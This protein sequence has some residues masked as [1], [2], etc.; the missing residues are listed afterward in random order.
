MIPAKLIEKKR[1]GIE[2]TPEE[3]D[4]FISD[5]MNEKIDDSQLSALLMSIYFN[6][7]SD[8]ETKSLVNS[9]VK[10]GKRFNF[11]HLNRYV[12]D[13]HSTGGIGDKISFILA[14]LLSSFD[15]IVPM[16][17]GRGLA[18][19]GG[20]IDKLESIKNFQ[21]QRTFDSFN[22]QIDEVGCGIISQSYEICPADKKLYSI[23]DLT[24]TIPSFSLICS[25]IMSK[26]IAAGL[27]GLVMDIKVGNG[28]FI[29]TFHEAKN[30]GTELKKIGNSFKINVDI[31]YSNMSQPL[32]KYA[33]L[34]C[35]IAEAV[36]C[37]KGNG[38]DDVVQLSL[39]LCSNILVQSGISKNKLE[40]KSLLIRN[41]EN[42]K[43]LKKFEEMIIAQEG[44][45]S[46]IY[47]KNEFTKNQMIIKSGKTGY[48][49]SINT[50]KIGWALVEMGC[51]RKVISDALDH[52]AGIKFNFKVSD[53]INKGDPIYELF[54][55]D[56]IK[57]KN[58][59]KMLTKTFIISEEKVEKEIL[60]I[61]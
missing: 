46:S 53:K 48:I 58:A 24:G 56:E 28:A 5:V 19:T 30:L 36:D 35:E 42:G 55:S 7:M 21:T 22:N 57:L 20:T 9:M 49:K 14:P 40:A 4:W 8:T 51:G 31:T 44:E 54:G 38:P 16:I 1:D 3:I 12:A 18:F 15:I 52:S 47:S 32:G 43:A 2:L 45:L 13:K 6:G 41:L 61:E 39:N 17:A 26:K 11:K 34:K 27:D 60:V 23:R 50:E 59:K 33:G 37:L 10:S 29:K 25:S